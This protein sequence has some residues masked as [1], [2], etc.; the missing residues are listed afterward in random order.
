MVSYVNSLKYTRLEA[1]NTEVNNIL[2]TST[3]YNAK[4]VHTIAS[5]ELTTVKL[6]CAILAVILAITAQC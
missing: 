2:R 5:Y 1:M 3:L 4:V 6:I